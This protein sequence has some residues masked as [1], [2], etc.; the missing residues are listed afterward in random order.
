MKTKS[1]ST[2]AAKP[3]E[4]SKLRQTVP[5]RDYVTNPYDAKTRPLPWVEFFVVDISRKINIAPNVSINPKVKIRKFDLGES[6]YVYGFLDNHKRY[7][8]DGILILACQRLDAM[9]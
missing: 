1:T 6:G 5:Y 2:K 7:D 4:K 8:Q 3:T 9:Q